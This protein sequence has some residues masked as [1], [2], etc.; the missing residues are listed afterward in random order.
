MGEFETLTQYSQEALRARCVHWW[1]GIFPGIWLWNAALGLTKLF[2]GEREGEGGK[3]IVAS[4][5]AEG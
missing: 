5:C 2:R 3:A 4:A 1:V